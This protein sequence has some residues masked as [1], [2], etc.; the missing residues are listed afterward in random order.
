MSHRTSKPEDSG[1]ISKEIPISIPPDTKER[2]NLL[3]MLNRKSANPVLFQYILPKFLK[4]T[5]KGTAEPIGDLMIATGE[6][7]GKIILI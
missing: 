6:D 5:N 2:I 7:A 4:V 3:N 1:I